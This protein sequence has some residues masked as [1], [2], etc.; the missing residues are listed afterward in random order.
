MVLLFWTA[1]LCE[2]LSPPPSPSKKGSL[3]NPLQIS[4][5]FHILLSES[6]LINISTCEALEG[7]ASHMKPDDNCSREPTL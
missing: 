2:S 4:S 3:N 1:S 6:S 5:F 7:S